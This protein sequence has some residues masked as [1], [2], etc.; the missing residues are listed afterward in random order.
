M[1]IGRSIPLDTAKRDLHLDNL[2]PIILL[3]IAPPQL[4]REGILYAAWSVP[5]CRVKDI[6]WAG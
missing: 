2:K 4:L 3:T 1:S 6:L 5:I